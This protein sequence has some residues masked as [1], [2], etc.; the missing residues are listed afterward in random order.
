MGQRRKGDICVTRN[1]YFVL[2]VNMCE[3][4]NQITEGTI[5]CEM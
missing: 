5:S 4:D 2:P 3:K 1:F